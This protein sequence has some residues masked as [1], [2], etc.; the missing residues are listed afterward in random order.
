MAA[1]VDIG[2]RPFFVLMEFAAL[3]PAQFIVNRISQLQ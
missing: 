1:R 3:K 2:H